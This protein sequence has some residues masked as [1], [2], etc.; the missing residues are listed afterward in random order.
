VK[1]VIGSTVGE[2]GQITIEKAVR[3]ALGVRPRDVAIQRVENGRL[4]VTFM[5]PAPAHCRSLAG[6]L[7]TPPHPP[8]G[9]PW[10]EAIADEVVADAI[11]EPRAAT[12]EAAGERA[13]NKPARATGHPGKR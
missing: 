8:T 9:Q 11:V 5:R 3:E 4:V 1:Y 10:D 2:R 13:R 12:A 7:G 6:I